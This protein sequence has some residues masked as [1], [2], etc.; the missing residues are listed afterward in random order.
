[1]LTGKGGILLIILAGAA[2]NA[3]CSAMTALLLNLSPNPALPCKD[4]MFWM[5]GSFENRT[6]DHVALVSA[7]VILG[8]TAFAYRTSPGSAPWDMTPPASLVYLTD[9]LYRQ[10]GLGCARGGCQRFRLPA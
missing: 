2:I 4:M 5:M 1:M 6:L 8:N 9:Q 7:P 10:I 3:F